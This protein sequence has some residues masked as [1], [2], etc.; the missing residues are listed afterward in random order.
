MSL[1]CTPLIQLPG[2]AAEALEFYRG[3]FGG[4]VTV[5]LYRDKGLVETAD[6]DRVWHGQLHTPAGFTLSCIDM[7]CGAMYELGA[8]VAISLDGD[9][10]A[11]L[12]SW[13]EALSDGG[14]VFVPLGFASP[15]PEPG[16]VTDRFGVEWAVK[17]PTLEVAQPAT[18]AATVAPSS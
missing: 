6:A 11:Q 7:P 1:R 14:E 15:V 8:T 18:S 10:E 9:D 3:V 17:I 16:R 12:R 13:F 4:D 5:S 2:R